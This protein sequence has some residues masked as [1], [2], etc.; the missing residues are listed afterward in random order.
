MCFQP[1]K[2]LVTQ[3]RCTG[4]SE[5]SLFADAIETKN[6]CAGPIVNSWTSPLHIGYNGMFVRPHLAIQRVKHIYLLL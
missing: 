2:A 1:A 4:S 5:P 6:S 3:R